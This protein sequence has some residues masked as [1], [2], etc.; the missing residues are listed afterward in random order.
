MTAKFELLN[1]ALLVA[2]E[3]YKDNARVFA[4][5]DDKAQKMGA[6]AGIFLGAFLA[7]LKPDTLL[8]LMRTTGPRGMWILTGV[9][10]LLISCVLICLAAMWV[11]RFPP[12]LSFG[13]M[14]QLT[15]DLFRLGE[16]GIT[17]EVKEGYAAEKLAV[18]KKCIL[19]QEKV[20]VRKMKLVFTAQAVLVAAMLA[21]SAMLILIIHF[22]GIWRVPSS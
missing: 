21:I 2:G 14:E 8:L 5:L 10:L 7:L 3:N 1:D 20:A 4:N 17:D 12:P 18:W 15:R 22:S 13:H 16:S 9:I 6:I 19:A 11:G